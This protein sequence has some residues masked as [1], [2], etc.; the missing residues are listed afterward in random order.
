MILNLTFDTD[1]SGDAGAVESVVR[2]ADGGAVR[3][4]GNHWFVDSS[5]DADTWGRR[6]LE[7]GASTFLVTLCSRSMAWRLGPEISSW[8]KADHRNWDPS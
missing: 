1:G 4:A 2:S 8:I 3:V 6:L 5:E 7:A